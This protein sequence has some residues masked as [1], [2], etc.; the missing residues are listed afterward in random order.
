MATVYKKFSVEIFNEE[1]KRRAVVMSLLATNGKIANRAVCDALGVDIWL[2]QCLPKDVPRV[3]KTK[4][5]A[6]VMVF[7]VVSSE[8]DVMP[9]HIFPKGLRIKTDD[10]INLM[11]TVVIP[12]IH[13]IIRDR[14]WVWQQDSAPCHTSRKSI[15]FL[16]NECF[17]MVGPD[18]WPPNSPKLESHGLFCFGRS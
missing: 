4:F 3:M 9:P 14:P 11:R 8:G 1:D 16:S 18:L 15:Q 7:G 6:T 13:G 10:Y 2:V 17:D 5:P 12:W